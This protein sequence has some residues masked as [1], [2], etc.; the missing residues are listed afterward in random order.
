MRYASNPLMAYNSFLKSV[1]CFIGVRNNVLPS[2]HH[3]PL[4][5]GFCIKSTQGI[6]LFLCDLKEAFCRIFT[7][8]GWKMRFASN[9]FM[10]NNFFLKSVFCQ[11]WVGKSILP[12]FHHF[13]L[14]N[15]FY[16][17]SSHAVQLFLKK[18]VL[19]NLGFKTAFCQILTI[20]RCNMRFASNPLMEDNSFLK[21]VFCY[22]VGWQKRCVKF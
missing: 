18:C 14:K 4:K 1:F 11:F 22:I 21:S 20:C 17:E 12:S 13:L 5:N 19:L 16:I 15:S 9:P 10:K 7:T 3:F 6:Q 8:S 2:F